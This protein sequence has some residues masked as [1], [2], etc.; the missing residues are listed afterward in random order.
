[1]ARLGAFCARHP[2]WVLVA[3]LVVV[4]GALG[5]QKAV[6]AKYDD[7]VS[8]PETPSA[9]GA[10]L[11]RTTDPAAAWPTGKVVFHVGSGTLA[12]HRGP[13]ARTIADLKALP[14]VITASGLVTSADGRT[15]YTVVSFDVDLTTLG[16]PYTRRLDQATEPARAD[17]VGVA[18]GGGLDQVVRPPPDQ[19]IGEVV[20]FGSALLVLLFMFGSVLAALLPVGSALVGVGAGIGILGMIAGVVTF[21]TSASGLA[22]MIALGVGIDYALFLTTRFRQDLMD[23]GSPREAAVRATATAGHAVLVAAITV[24]VALL[25]LYAAGLTFIG[26]LGFAGAVGVAVASAAAL[27]LTPA[28]LTLLGHRIDRF[29]VRRPVA[30]SS[31][32][33][34]GWLRYATLVSRHP[35][36]FLVA[37]AG[38][39]ALMAVPLFSIRLGHVDEG[40]DPVGSTTRTAYD[41]I[42]GA[43]GPGFGPGANGTFTVVVDGRRATAS[44]G[45]ITGDLDRALRDTR[46]VA[47][48]TPPAPGL[49]GRILVTTVTPAT[50]PQTSATGELYTALTERTL[51]DALAGTGAKAYV[52]GALAG[53]FDFRDTVEARLPIIIGIVLVAAFLLLMVVFRS[54]LVPLKAV[55]LNLLTTAASYGALV[56]A[57]QWGWGD[58]L[59]GLPG[60]V[61]IESFVPMMMF[62]IVFGL[63]MDYEIFLLSRIAEAWRVSR[64]NT[65]S[66]GAG[67][68]IT[69]RVI[70]SAA[71]IMTLVFLG[72]TVT[73][74]VTIKMLAVGLAFSVIL[75]ATIVRLVLVPSLMVLVGDANWWL[76][77]PLARFLPNLGA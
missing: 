65:E 66:V 53:Q 16:N 42:A 36:P 24:A 37:G 54:L 9:I 14:H 68:A 18:Y 40:A 12:D 77:R 35:W 62:A 7:E 26:K 69:G 73:P 48:F 32:M 64:D 38:L 22:I 50:G 29:R 47:S 56:A 71:L 10:H 34:D 60:P 61:P 46:G 67:L 19:T 72:F 44:T 17:G 51:P 76:P 2:V 70:S 75:D 25:S 1:M 6:H 55:L 28:A 58:G 45:Q 33:R 41:W 31:G 30:E 13:I 57:F 43:S 21:G 63:S 52:T 5:G 27:T 11:L 8:L 23:G 39:L 49:A 20:G 3:W 59:L 4:V 15:A 74:D